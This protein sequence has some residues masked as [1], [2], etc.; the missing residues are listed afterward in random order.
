MVVQATKSAAI[1]QRLNELA[2]STSPSEFELRALLREVEQ[3]KSVDAACYY[4]LRGMV[5]SLSHKYEDSKE[6]HEKSLKLAAGSAVFYVN[7]ALSMRRLGR[8]LEALN[9]VLKALELEPSSQATLREVLLTMIYAGDFSSFESVRE[10]FL[11]ANP[12]IEFEGIEEAAKVMSIRKD[13]ERVGIPSEEYKIAVG[14]V[15][16]IL[17]DNS[18]V[19]VSS[20]ISSSGYDGVLHLSTYYG[21]DLTSSA[22]LKKVNDE[23]ADAMAG[24]E[25]LTCWDQMVFNVVVA[26]PEDR[27]DI[28]DVA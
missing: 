7:Y 26:Q 20:M 19:S 6:Y 24:A 23:I 22:I 1:T 12:A 11:K 21:V 17:Y 14:I 15:E 18:L 3:L 16:K 10:K 4:M 5:F 8:S 25:N 27:S 28:T 13:I 9:L 2:Q